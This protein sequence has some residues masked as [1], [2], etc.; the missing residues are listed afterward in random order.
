MPG[1]ASVAV[2][3]FC[4]TKSRK[5]HSGS[6]HCRGGSPKVKH[7]LRTGTVARRHHDSLGNLH[8][9]FIDAGSQLPSA[10]GIAL[11]HPE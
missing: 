2:H 9:S 11:G 5:V 4:I 6:A 1:I 8:A 10:T 3:D 7:C